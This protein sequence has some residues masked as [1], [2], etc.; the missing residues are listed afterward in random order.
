M[1]VQVVFFNYREIKAFENE[2]SSDLMDLHSTFQAPGKA[3]GEK[4]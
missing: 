3:R 4:P 1:P 2:Q